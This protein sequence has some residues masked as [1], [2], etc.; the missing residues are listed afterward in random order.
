MPQ[1]CVAG[2]CS[3]IRKDGVSLHQRPEDPR[4]ARPWTN[5][6]KNTRSDFTN[7]TS[8]SRLCSTHFTVDCFQAKSSIVKSLGLKMKTFWKDDAVPTIVKSGPP[9]NKRQRRVK[10]NNAASDSHRNKSIATHSEGHTENE[11]LL[12]YVIKIIK[13]CYYYIF[14]VKI[15]YLQLYLPFLFLCKD[16]RRAWTGG[17]FDFWW[18]CKQLRGRK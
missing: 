18:L 7:P 10:D 16:H 6:V 11:K 4:F 1:R 13:N 15:I 3:N 5:A 17:K 8:L 14:I 2:G 9:P 12:G